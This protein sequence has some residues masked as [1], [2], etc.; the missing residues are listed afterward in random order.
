[1]SA[2]A[3]CF[4]QHHLSSHPALAPP[5]HTTMA[6]DSKPK[7]TGWLRPKV[8]HLFSSSSRSSGARNGRGG[9]PAA[10]DLQAVVPDPS[11]TDNLEGFIPCLG[12]GSHVPAVGPEQ[13][14][15][16]IAE[17]TPPASTTPSASTSVFS[18]ARHFNVGNIQINS[19]QHVHNTRETIDGTAIQCYQNRF[20]Y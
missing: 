12:E 15:T 17:S 11:S 5:H 2:M 10:Q 4:P 6:P 13:G 18:N 14:N 16:M 19:P 9:E 20:V 7:K 1:M 8:R 3:S